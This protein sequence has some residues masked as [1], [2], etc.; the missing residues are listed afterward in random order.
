[1]HI[2]KKKKEFVIP[3]DFFILFSYNRVFDR[4]N[5]SQYKTTIIKKMSDNFNKKRLIAII[6]I[7]SSN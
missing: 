7:A 5:E 4:Q 6:D 2:G 3:C 1:M